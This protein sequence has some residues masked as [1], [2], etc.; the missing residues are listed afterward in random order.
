[1]AI[2][3]NGD[4][5]ERYFG[6]VLKVWEQ[7]GYHDSDFYCKVW[8]D[9]EGVKT[10]E[11][12]TTRC[13]G[14]GYAV[15]DASKEVIAKANKWMARQSYYSQIKKGYG[16]RPIEKGLVVKVIKG[17]KV[18][19][20]LFVKVLEIRENDYQS[21]NKRVLVQLNEGSKVWTYQENLETNKYSINEKINAKADLFKR[22]NIN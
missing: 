17:R 10:I 14:H 20:G 22:V 11:Y 18:K 2:L 12:D 21:Y 13:G 5:I 9:K 7:N 4:N 8:D 15:I 19:K 3:I 1:M 16:N 6:S